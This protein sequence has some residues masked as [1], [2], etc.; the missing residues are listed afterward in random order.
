MPSEPKL[1]ILV[2]EV[3]ARCSA[4]FSAPDA[5]PHEERM[6]RQNARLRLRLAEER[7]ESSGG[8]RLLHAMAQSDPAE[9][10]EQWA[11]RAALTWCAVPEISAARVVWLDSAVAAPGDGT[12]ATKPKADVDSPP[13]SADQRPPTLILPLKL[14][15]RVRLSV[16]LWSD[17]DPTELER[18]L[19]LAATRAAWEAWATQVAERA[20]LER[21]L[22]AVV[23]AFHRQVESEETRLRRQKF[24]AL[25]EFAAG[26]GHELNNPLAVVVGRAQLL[27]ARTDDPEM[28]RSLRIILNQAGRAH[29]ILRDL[30][31]V[32]RPSAPERRPCRP[33]E[34]LL[35]SVR[36]FQDECRA[37]G[38][39]LAV[40]IDES[41]PPISSEPEALRHLAEI[42]LRNAVEA[43]PSGGTIQVRSF[44]QGGELLWSFADTGRG[45]EPGEAAHLLDPFY[46][47]RQA[48]RGLGLGLPRAASIVD[49]AGG[50]LLWSSTPGHGSLFQIHLPITSATA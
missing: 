47:G 11:S 31:F 50:A 1:R 19:A 34:L 24:D 12:D 39:R 30:M 10:P 40:E 26:A 21:R 49:L 5:T 13:S 4:P 6:T 28:T 33:P 38:I 8:A 41:S 44:L 46:C 42:L 9:T 7:R 14:R 29:R 3:Q 23:A 35:A 17:R 37:R 18:R 32:A 43:T 20:L 16:H 45:F 27:L 15:G 22:Q 25:G 48:G 2:A 36:D